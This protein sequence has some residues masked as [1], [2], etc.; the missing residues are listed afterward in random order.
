[1]RRDPVAKFVMLEAYEK[2]G[3]AVRRD[4][5][6]D[7]EKTAY[8]QDT[9]L[10]ERLATEKLRRRVKAVL[11]EGWKWVG[12]LFREQWRRRAGERLRSMTCWPLRRRSRA[13]F[14][15]SSQRARGG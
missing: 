8:L 2:A 13:M 9:A 11:A 14:P 10:L 15:A 4:A 3:G 6:S 12:Q 7:D 1:M 5:F